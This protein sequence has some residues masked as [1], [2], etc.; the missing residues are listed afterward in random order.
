M[1]TAPN[2]ATQQHHTAILVSLVDHLRL[3][4]TFG[5]QSFDE[6]A[7]RVNDAESYGVLAEIAA[8]L[9]SNTAEAV[10]EELRKLWADA[11]TTAAGSA[12]AAAPAA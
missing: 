2:P 7:A 1:I 10:D 8:G 4:E 9:D 5:C 3:R 6:A 11:L 12:A